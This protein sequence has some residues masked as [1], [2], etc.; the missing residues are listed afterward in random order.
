MH[1]TFL[2]Q[3]IQLA[4]DNVDSGEGGPYGALIVKDNRVIAASVNQVTSAIDP[5]AHAEIMAIR[6]ACKRLNDFQLIGCV[7]YTS[8]EP[9]PMCLGAIYWARLDT[10]YYAGNRFDAATANFDDSFIYD[11][12]NLLPQ[13]RRIPMHHINLLNAREPFDIW[14][15]KVDKIP[16]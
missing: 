7:L 6:A 10:V 2:Q 14:N 3:A 15:K 11:E 13:H 1:E 5:T 4:S 8:C 16:Y 9:C 12:I